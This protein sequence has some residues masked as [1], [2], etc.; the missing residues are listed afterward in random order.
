MLD[1]L[2][3]TYLDVRGVGLS[4]SPLQA[5]HHRSLPLPGLGS[6]WPRG[7]WSISHCEIAYQY[8]VKAMKE[9]K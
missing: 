4:R 2:K 5:G 1:L 7:G 9:S 6:L 8:N 3:V